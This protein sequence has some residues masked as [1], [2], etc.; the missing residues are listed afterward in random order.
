MKIYE[1]LI[2]SMMLNLTFQFFFKV[3]AINVGPQK[4]TTS[5]DRGSYNI[6]YGKYSNDPKHIPLQKASTRVNIEKDSGATKASTTASS[7]FC[8]HFARGQ[9]A[10]GY[11]CSFLHRIPTADDELNLGIPLTM[12]IFGREKHRF[13]REDMGGG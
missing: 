13:D 1:G 12:D 11:E 7:T 10:K 9:C 2:K 8:F 4:N 6:W 3:E 5:R